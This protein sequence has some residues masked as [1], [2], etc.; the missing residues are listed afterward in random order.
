MIALPITRLRECAYPHFE[1]IDGNRQKQQARAIGEF[2]AAP[3]TKLKIHAIYVSPLLRAYNTA[4]QIQLHQP[5]VPR[6][7][8]I[9]S[10]LLREQHF[11]DAEGQSPAW[12]LLPSTSSE[13]PSSSSSSYNTRDKN[14][15][16]AP[17]VDRYTRFPNGESCEDV[18][19]RVDA[20]ISEFIIPHMLESLPDD[21]P[22]LNIVVV[23]HGIAIAE[24]IGAF[25]R[26]DATHS[27][28]SPGTWRGLTNTG[29]TQ[30]S[31]SLQV[32]L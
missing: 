31:V 6:P 25:L 27:L 19:Q 14:I 16:Y 12:G 22:P 29:W 32:C 11:G 9:R 15:S 23:S 4:E 5:T 18:A 2:F 13:T 3:S 8:L 24:L 26:R 28:S 1:L 17:P 21:N 10:D 20:F 7:P 30:L